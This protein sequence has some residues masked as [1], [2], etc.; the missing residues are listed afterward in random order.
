[1]T[2]YVAI[3]MFGGLIDDVR[4]FENY[5]DAYNHVVNFVGNE[6]DFGFDFENLAKTKYEG[7][8]VHTT[9]LE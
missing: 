3:L 5:I 6:T 2:V 1:M 7:T 4:T 9:D 8:G